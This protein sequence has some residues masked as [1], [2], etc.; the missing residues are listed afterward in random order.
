MS[1]KK[2]L[3]L[4]EGKRFLER[5][6]EPRNRGSPWE[7][8]LAQRYRRKDKNR[9]KGYSQWASNAISDFTGKFELHSIDLIYL[10]G[11]KN[12]S[13]VL[14]GSVAGLKN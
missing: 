5:E 12:I 6:E 13:F 3:G 9:K 2:L 14:L 7:Y 1:E 10:D 11:R 8:R 4:K